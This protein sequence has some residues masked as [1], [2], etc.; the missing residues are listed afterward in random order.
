[1]KNTKLS[2]IIPVLHLN[3]PLNKKR[4]FMPRQTIADTLLQLSKAVTMSHEIIVICN[5]QDKEL[6]DFVR[7]HPQINRYCINS[8]NVGVARAWNMGAQLADGDLLCYLND[9]VAVGEI[10]KD[11]RSILGTFL[12]TGEVVEKKVS[13]LSGGERTRLALCVLL[14]S[15]SNF[16][17]LEDSTIGEIGPA[18]SYWKNCQH[19][20]FV[21]SQNAVA[22][23]V[24]SGFCFLMRSDLFH[25][26][27]GFDINFTPAGCEEIDMSYRVRQAGYKCIVDQSVDIKH[28]HHHGVSAQKV[29]INYM[30]KVIDT[31][32]LHLINSKKF[33]EKWNGINFPSLD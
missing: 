19:E 6:I 9:D 16:L 22:A 2:I 30:G 3:R 21:E 20:R 8:T 26:L 11:L 25:K 23:D 31:E 5:G 17:I 10:R 18:G 33:K 14:L 7:S 13:V 24:V 29:D 15:P 1:M 12:F 28:F 4:F 32:T 27:G